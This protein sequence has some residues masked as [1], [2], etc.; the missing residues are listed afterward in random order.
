MFCFKTNHVAVL[1]MFS[2]SAEDAE[3][4]SLWR[5]LFP[6]VRLNIRSVCI[7]VFH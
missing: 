3:S 4:Y 6:F 1:F 5:D 7:L 2:K